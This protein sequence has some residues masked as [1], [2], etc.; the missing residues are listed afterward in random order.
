MHPIFYYILVFMMTGAI[1]MAIAN[2]RVDRKTGWERWLKYFTYVLITGLVI[3]SIFLHYFLC[4]AAIISVF[5]LTELLQANFRST[6]I[7]RTTIIFSVIV[8][9]VIAAGFLFF[10]KTFSG[11]YVL[12][13]YFQV[14]IFDAFCQIVGQLLG[15]RQLIPSVSPS[16]TVE[17][18]A[19]GWI[20]CLV[21]AGLSSGWI[22]ISFLSSLFVGFITG[23]IA[24][25]G[26]ILASYYKRKLGIKDYSNWLPG[27]GGFLDRF[28]SFLF[29]GFV[30]YLISLLI[31]REESIF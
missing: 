1:G 15:K 26:D 2:R 9:L 6:A 17:G 29:T 23:V 30:Y 4:V 18:F 21:A 5:A 10:A 24:F 22:K 20:F 19:G 25:Y 3:A 14:L 7:S 8:F 27:Q 31:F 13:I 16:K 11:Q 28:D 12:F